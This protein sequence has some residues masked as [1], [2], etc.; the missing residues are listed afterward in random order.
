MNPIS[1]FKFYDLGA[2][3]H[4]ATSN[5]TAIS[6]ADMFVPL[7]E[8]QAA[9]DNLLKGDPITLELAKTDASA[10]LNRLGALFNKHFIDPSTRQFRHPAR[11]D[12]VEAHELNL[13][14]SMVEKFESA[15]AAE[16][17]RKAIYAVPKRGLFDTW[18]L[19][20]QAEEQFSEEVRKNL[21]EG[22]LGDVRAAG[23][24]LAFGLGTA[25][26]F[27]LVRSVEAVLARYVDTM[28]GPVPAKAAQLWREGITRLQ[29]KAKEGNG[30]DARVPS[31]LADIDTRYRAGL[32]S[33]D[34]QFSLHDAMI[35]FG[36]AGS[37]I[38]LMMEGIAAT[39]TPQRR[40]KAAEERLK[41]VQQEANDEKSPADFAEEASAPRRG[42]TG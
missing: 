1:Q 28:A 5:R 14:R 15:L 19:A 35:F 33:H 36:M 12:V 2:K 6:A 31:L 10:L 23:R 26:C 21:P 4:R 25:A 20:E 38:T 11:E 7:M 34:A 30:V 17:S 42:K 41:D 40:L 29:N 39:D 8:A 16:L 9:L 13:L 27:H 37:L 22:A 24:C 32:L 18:Q 3:L